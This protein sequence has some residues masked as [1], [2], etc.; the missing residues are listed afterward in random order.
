[1]SAPPV[2]VTPAVLRDWALPRPGS[3]KESRGQLLVLGGSRSTPGAVLLAG[4][5]ALRAGAG[6]L[7]LA[8][9]EDATSALAVAVP[10]AAVVALPRGSG[11]DLDP[12]AAAL[13]QDRLES[14]DVVVAGPGLADPE[15]ARDLLVAAAPRLESALVLDALGSAYLTEH[16]E[17]LHHLGGRVVLKVNPGE[18]ARTA[19]C[20]VDEVEDDPVG[21]ASRV[22]ERS[23]VVVL[24]GGT[25]KHVVSPDGRTWVVEG[26]GP[27]LG[28]SGSGDTQA[29]IVGGLLARGADPCQAAVW[30]AFVHA[31]V[32]ERLTAEV[33]TLGYLAREVP[34]HVPAVLTELGA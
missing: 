31:R 2:V 9:V 22:A 4:E 24:C 23:Q 17:G 11:D 1:V 7:V 27:G 28:V 12:S 30:A 16:P 3:G 34:P 10:E 33:G 20:D 29:G 21:P 15:A 19:H 18:R 26:G 13:L 5:A 14:A 32:G 6:K 8:T 25:S